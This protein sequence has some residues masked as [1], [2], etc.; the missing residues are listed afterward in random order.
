MDVS[1]FCSTQF[2]PIRDLFAELWED[3]EVGAALA[4]YWQGKEVVNL[5]AGFQDR[6]KSK[7]WTEETLVNTY[8]ITK[9]VMA[10]AITQ[11]AE[12]GKIE[13][14][15][16]VCHYWPEFAQ[17][18]KHNITVREL[19]S[20][21]SGL[22]GIEQ[23][24]TVEDLYDW[25]KI[26]GLLETQPPLWTPGT[27]A[28]YHAVTWGYLCGELIYRI[29]GL[30]PGEYVKRH[31]CEPLGLE[32]YL[33]VPDKKL[34]HCAELIGP[35]HI[36]EKSISPPLKAANS[37]APANP[38]FDIA[39]LN[40]I[41][42]PFKHASSQPWRRAEIPASNGHSDAVSLARLYGAL[43][44]GGLLEDTRFLTVAA[45]DQAIEVAVDNDID[46]VMGH[47]IRRS[48]A[49]FILSHDG[50]YGQEPRSFGHAGAGGSTAFADPDHSLGFAYVMNQLQPEGFKRRYAVIL[51]KIYTL[52]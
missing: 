23:P 20:H 46:Q 50:N 51:D 45:I 18:G 31:I 41:I 52:I 2:S 35:N 19:L 29:S 9:G 17:N 8:S 37:S 32:F 44:N 27:M 7:P 13:Y 11:L 33:G 25:D 34:N 49:G 10:T 16:K 28:G 4:V 42:S 39:Q 36:T 43:A 24:L 40:P 12:Q 47:V 26:I 1:G 6:A 14:S 48:Q 22:C 3:I 21:Q 30:T 15:E 5:W 38:L